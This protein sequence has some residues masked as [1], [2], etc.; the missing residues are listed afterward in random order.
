MK[1]IFVSLDYDQK[2]Y[3]HIFLEWRKKR[4]PNKNIS[5]SGNSSFLTNFGIFLPQGFKTKL[6]ASCRKHRTCD[7]CMLVSID[8]DTGLQLQD[9]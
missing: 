6:V 3:L 9:I 2:Y 5:L 1:S 4:M 7:I 8:T